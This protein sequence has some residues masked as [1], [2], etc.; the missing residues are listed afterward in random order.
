[1]E[2]RGT[3]RVYQLLQVIS[4]IKREKVNRSKFPYLHIG[5]EYQG[6]VRRASI[7][8]KLEVIPYKGQRRQY[9]EGKW[10]RGNSE[11]PG[12]NWNG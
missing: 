7:I 1:M 4:K 10:A 12:R 6:D 3:L 8:G 11:G 5:N 9:E 2:G